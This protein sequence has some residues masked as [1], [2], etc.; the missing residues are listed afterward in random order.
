MRKKKNWNPPQLGWIWDD[1]PVEKLNIKNSTLTCEWQVRQCECTFS[2]TSIVLNNGRISGTR[3][4]IERG[5]RGNP[6]SEL[7][8]V[9]Y[10]A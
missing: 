7:Q 10:T 8:F 1:S 6:G 2:Y 4:K 9:T 5:E 3:R